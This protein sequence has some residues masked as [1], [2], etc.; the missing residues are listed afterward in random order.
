MVILNYLTTIYTFLH[1]STPNF[2]KS[3]TAESL[4]GQ[5]FHCLIVLWLHFLHFFEYTYTYIRIRIYLYT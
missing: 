4:M 3:V 5:G 1:L 2:F